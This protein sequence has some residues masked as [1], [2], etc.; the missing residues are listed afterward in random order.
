MINHECQ[1][2]RRFTK[3]SEFDVACAFHDCAL[4][5]LRYS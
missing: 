3:R 5:I 4:G 2:G 1:V